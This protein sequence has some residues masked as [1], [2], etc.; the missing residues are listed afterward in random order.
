MADPFQQW[1]IFS[2]HEAWSCCAPS[3]VL[4]AIKTSFAIYRV[5][6]TNHGYLSF[7][8]YVY[9][10]LTSLQPLF[11]HTQLVIEILTSTALRDY[12]EVQSASCIHLSIHDST[13]LC[14]T[15]A[16]FSVSW[17]STKSVDSLDK[18]QPVARP[19]SARRTTETRKK[20]TQTSMPQVGFE[21]MTTVFERAKTH[22]IPSG[23]CDRLLYLLLL[24]ILRELW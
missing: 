18:D 24:Y 2:V 7:D 4:L 23:H 5:Y 22:D 6:P 20:R 8:I 19:L 13:A 16:A 14:W 17:S 11:I 3:Q 9:H 1:W 12:T 15:L 10:V 21:P